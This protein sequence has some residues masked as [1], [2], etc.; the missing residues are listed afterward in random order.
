MVFV[1]LARYF[2]SIIVAMFLA[3]PLWAEDEISSASGPVEVTPET[4]ESVV[5]VPVD[6]DTGTVNW[7]DY[8]SL[9]AGGGANFGFIT[10]LYP[11]DPAALANCPEILL[12]GAWYPPIPYAFS[13]SP[14]TSGQI[15]ARGWWYLEDGS[16]NLARRDMTI[17]ANG[18][19]WYCSTW[20][21][22]SGWVFHIE[23]SWP[24]GYFA[25]SYYLPDEYAG[26]GIDYFLRSVWF[27]GVLGGDRMM[28]LLDYCGA[29]RIGRDIMNGGRDRLAIYEVPP[30]E[31]DRQNGR[32]NL[33]VWLTTGDWRLV[34]TRLHAAYAIEVTE[35]Q[36][37]SIA[38]DNDPNSF[39]SDFLPN[40]IFLS[41]D[42]YL[43]THETPFFG[44]SEDVVSV[45]PQSLSFSPGSPGES[46]ET[47]EEAG[48]ESS[49]GEATE[50][51]S[52]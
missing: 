51:L 11:P 16:G 45:Q 28:Q 34:R 42:Q 27:R 4:E 44:M 32:G 13:F 50:D 29:Q 36:N 26:P 1:M 2:L 14:P 21:M 25:E 38:V 22:G 47:G 20:F 8:L 31:T 48:D 41:I 12:D 52:E 15:A 18:Q 19:E 7:Q 35:F 6:E 30:N 39:Y 24:T 3:F 37:V 5:S 46:G 9:P 17:S 40:D 49:E 33:L 43:L 23:E 10:V